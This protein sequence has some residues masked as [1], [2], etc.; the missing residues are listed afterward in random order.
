MERGQSSLW[1]PSKHKLNNATDCQ[2]PGLPCEGA[3]LAEVSTSVLVWTDVSNGED[4]AVESSVDIWD[5]SCRSA[6]KDKA[7]HQPV[8][9]KIGWEP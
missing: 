6:E 3:K 4:L 1:H 5:Q 7:Y 8:F 2:R 9:S